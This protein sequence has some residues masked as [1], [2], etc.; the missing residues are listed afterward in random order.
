M[1]YLGPY[2][3]KPL[4]GSDKFCFLRGH[5]MRREEKPGWEAGWW[6]TTSH[7][8]CPGSDGKCPRAVSLLG[9]TFHES[10]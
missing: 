9:D 7:L 1:A 3:S 10:F 2:G 5:E 6:S 4:S 8:G